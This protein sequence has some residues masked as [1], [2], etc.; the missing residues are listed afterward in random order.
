MTL[1]CAASLPEELL[2][3]NLNEFGLINLD[4]V[5]CALEPFRTALFEGFRKTR[6]GTMREE[7]LIGLHPVPKTPS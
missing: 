1:E 6:D 4:K 5:G 2:R 7:L 3:R